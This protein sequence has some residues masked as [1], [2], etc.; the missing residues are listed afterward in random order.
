LGSGIALGLGG[1][2]LIAGEI[3]KSFPF[4]PRSAPPE[5]FPLRMPELFSGSTITARSG[6]V[7]IWPDAP[8]PIWGF[9]GLYP[10]PTIRAQRGANF[11]VTLANELDDETIIHWHGLTVPAAMDGHPRLAIAHG[12]TYDYSFT[13][14]QRAGTYWYHPHPDMMTGMQVY[15]GMAGFFIVEDPEEQALA[16]PRDKYEVPLLL[17]DRRTTFDRQFEYVLGDQDLLEGLLG[18]TIL[19]NGTANAYFEVDRGLYRFR[20]LNGSNA[21]ILKL[22]LSDGKPFHL[23]ATDGGLLDKPVEVTQLTMSPAERAELLIDFSSYAAGSSVALKSAQFDDLGGGHQG[24]EMPIL[25]FDVGSA[26]GAPSIIP[27]TLSQLTKLDPASATTNRTFVFRSTPG[28]AT[29]MHTINGK[30]FDMT[31]IDETMRPNDIEV[32]TFTNLSPYPHP[33]HVHGGQFQVID[34]GGDSNLAP[35]YIGWKDTVLM[36]PYQPIRVVM[37]IPEFLGVFLLHCHNLEHEDHGMMMNFEVTNASG[38]EGRSTA[39]PE[40][41]DLTRKEMVM[42][43]H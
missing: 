11:A 10:G 23:I 14:A 28:S 41:M 20:V 4:T 36:Q 32:W 16:L 8:T 37:R 31:R 43:R 25:R 33:V 34:V 35:E 42:P 15:K 7:Q 2:P 40:K 9:N 1:L 39:T 30:A 27:T 22:A 21:R 26:A 24:N 29:M 18:D 13:V 12:A 5:G 17:Q 3:T 19:A 38:V 6:Q